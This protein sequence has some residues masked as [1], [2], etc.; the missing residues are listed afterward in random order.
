LKRACTWRL[1]FT[2]FLKKVIFYIVIYATSFEEHARKYNLLIKRLRRANLKLQPGKCEFLK[3]EIIYLGH[4]ISKDGVKSDPKKL[5]A[6]RQ[7]SR[8]KTPKN[9]K[10]FLGLTR[11]YKRFIP[12]FSKLVKSL[13]NLLKND[14]RFEWTSAQEESFEILKQKLCEEPVLQYPDFSKPFILTTDASGIAVEGILSQGEINKDRP[15]IYASRTLNDNEIKYDTYEKEA[16]AIIYCVKHF[17][18][19]V[20]VPYI[21]VRTKIHLGYGS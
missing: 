11:Y 10:Q 19:H 5:E 9:I 17:R 13:T 8:P 3:T 14:T 1:F 21:S 16:L 4:V 12:S 15:I 7:F 2:F 6:V 18:P 20:S